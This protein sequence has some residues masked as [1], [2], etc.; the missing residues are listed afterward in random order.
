MNN[1][2]IWIFNGSCGRF[3]SG[4]FENKEEAEEWINRCFLSGTLTKY[5][6]EISAYDWAVTNDYFKPKK[7]HQ[8][9]P[10]FIGKFTAG[11]ID[12]YHYENEI[13]ENE[14][15]K[16]TADI[17][18]AILRWVWV[19]T[20]N[21]GRFPS[22]VFEHKNEAE[23][24]IRCNSLSG[25]LARYPVGISVYEWAIKSNIFSPQKE[26]QKNP[27]FVSKFGFGYVDH[28]FYEDGLRWGYEIIELTE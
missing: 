25:I 22:G 1:D 14:E 24:W 4:V 9:T 26:I 16:P 18:A 21:G 5:P 2:W 6:L 3:P 28:Y 27:E 15:I 23:K 12:H 8:K 11:C 13:S 10:D 7:E 19:F 20:G 17:D